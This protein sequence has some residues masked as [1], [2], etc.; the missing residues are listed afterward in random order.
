MYE[1]Y[2]VLVALISG[3]LTSSNASRH[4]NVQYK[5][6]FIEQ[7]TTW[8]NF[9]KSLETLRINYDLSKYLKTDHHFDFV[10]NTSSFVGVAAKQ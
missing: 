2:V 10:E 8:C 5:Q 9:G 4:S 6:P 7:L 1:N 3:T